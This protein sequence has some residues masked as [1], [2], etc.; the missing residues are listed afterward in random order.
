MF[1]DF[2]ARQ[3]DK[4]AGKGKEIASGEHERSWPFRACLL[5]SPSRP[6]SCSSRVSP[7]RLVIIYGVLGAAF[8]PFLALTLIWLLNSS[9]TP[10]GGRN[11]WLSNT[12]LAVAGLL[13]LVLCLKEIWDQ[14]WAEFF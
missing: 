8:M 6:S 2:V 11:G 13:F 1:A 3:R 5:G 4:T 14:P 7:S 10:R 12:M 9:R